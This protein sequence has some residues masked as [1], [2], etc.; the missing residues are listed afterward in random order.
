MNTQSYFNRMRLE[1]LPPAT[2]DPVVRYTQGLCGEFAQALSSI[3]GWPVVLVVSN[4]RYREGLHAV[5]LRPDGLF[6][7]VR[8]VQTEEELLAHWRSFGPCRV[9]VD[10]L[11][12]GFS[13]WPLLPF[14][15][16]SAIK[17]IT[18]HRQE[19]LDPV[20]P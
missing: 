11:A 19:L 13:A 5:C 12:P 20:T 2:V 16:R 6:V 9:G 4:D 10:T 15:V 3:T 8:G 7:D 17:Y 18:D 14:E 1:H